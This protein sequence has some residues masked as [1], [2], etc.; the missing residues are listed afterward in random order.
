MEIRVKLLL[1]LFT[2]PSSTSCLIK[3]SMVAVFTDLTDS[4]SLLIA[5]N[6]PKNVQMV[7]H[8]EFSVSLQ[9]EDVA[10][11]NCEKFV[12]PATLFLDFNSP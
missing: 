4:H 10:L 2:L 3:D 1:H 12:S 8:T 11:K 9:R 7:A 6:V 5:L